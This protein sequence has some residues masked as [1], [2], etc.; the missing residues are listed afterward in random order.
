[1]NQSDVRHQISFV[2]EVGKY[3]VCNVASVDFTEVDNFTGHFGDF[4]PPDSLLDVSLD[5]AVTTEHKTVFIALLKKW[6]GYTNAEASQ[7]ANQVST[8]REAF[9]FLCENVKPGSNIDKIIAKAV[10]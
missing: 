8:Y 4:S 3:A 7:V 6:L 1:M 2:G 10:A 9:N 5:A